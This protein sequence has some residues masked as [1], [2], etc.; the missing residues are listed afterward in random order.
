MHDDPLL[1]KKKLRAHFLDARKNLSSTAVIEKSNQII[2]KLVNLSLFK[3]SRVIHC[4]VS[5]NI[6]KEVH[7]HEF[8]NQSI[9]KE[10]KILVPKMKSG[11]RLSHSA[12]SS[13]DELEIN[14]W[15]VPEPVTENYP[16]SSGIDLVIVPMVSGD[17][18]LNRLGYGMGYYDRFLKDLS[19]FKIGLLFDC[20]LYDKALPVEEFDIPLDML[21]TES[22][23]VA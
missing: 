1:L 17:R 19:A 9:Q 13:L 7:T 11:G 16:D 3:S 18:K 8:I 21:I 23:T 15:G 12:I 4:Y 20:Q 6:R 10:K 22:E 5:M 2:E 14:E